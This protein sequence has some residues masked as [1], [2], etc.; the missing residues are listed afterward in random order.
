[1][2][3]LLE[4]DTELTEEE[5]TLFGGFGKGA[6]IRPPFR[7]LNPGRIFIGEYVSIREEAY[8]HAYEDLT[9]LHKYVADEYKG[10]FDLDDY[11][12]DSKIII[13]RETHIG[14][15][16]FISCTN[17]VEIGANVT[18]SE[19]TFIGDN[20]H[21]YSHPNVPIIQ[22]PNTAG[23]PIDIGFGSWIGVGTAIL[24][25]TTL[26]IN[27]VVGANSIVQGVYPDRAVIGSGKAMLLYIDE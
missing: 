18:I 11:R 7:I 9:K 19:R 10:D 2:D 12:Y 15:N 5:K 17:H 1:M 26:G 22:Q 27:N 16:L 23:D 8:I 21:T 24:P 4:K 20:S 14:R 3:I 25:G 6:R 13:G